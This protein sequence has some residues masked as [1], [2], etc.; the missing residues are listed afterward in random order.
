MLLAAHFQAMT[1]SH[2]QAF[3]L[4]GPVGSAS[5]HLIST[6]CT[7]SHT[8]SPP[9]PVELHDPTEGTLT[10]GLS[11]SRYTP[12]LET[13][14]LVQPQLRDLAGYIGM[15]EQMFTDTVTQWA[16]WAAVGAGT[17]QAF[18]PDIADALLGAAMLAAGRAPTDAERQRC[19]ATLW[20]GVD[21]TLKTARASGA[22][23]VAR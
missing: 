19:L 4:E 15:P 5:Q 1:V 18:T 10:Y 3:V 11:Y 6:L 16:T 8:T 12:L 9:P 20:Q 21:L 2:D 23:G 22:L 14:D 7:G 13:V 17:E